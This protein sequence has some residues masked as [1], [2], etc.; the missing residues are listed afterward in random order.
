[1]I[2]S[3]ADDRRLLARD[4]DIIDRAAIARV[5]PRIPPPEVSVVV[6]VMRILIEIMP[7][8]NRKS[9]IGLVMLYQKCGIIVD[10]GCHV[11]NLFVP[12]LNLFY[13]CACKQKPPKD[14]ECSTP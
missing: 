1:M 12:H 10:P 6:V 7:V 4:A 11:P 13:R 14:D 5:V 2:S 9:Y 8:R 3:Q